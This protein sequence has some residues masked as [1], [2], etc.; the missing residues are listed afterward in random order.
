MDHVINKKA[1]LVRV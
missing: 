1:E